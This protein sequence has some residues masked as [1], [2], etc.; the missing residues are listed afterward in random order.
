MIAADVGSLPSASYGG[1][2]RIGI[3]LRHFSGE[4]GVIDWA[5]ARATIPKTNPPAGGDFHLISIFLG[6]CPTW[7]LGAFDLGAC[8]DAELD[9]LRGSG[10][11]VS[12]T[13]E[14]S[15]R[16][17][18]VGASTLARLKISRHFSLPL[19]LGVLLPLEHP[20]FTLQGVA[21]DQGRVHKPAKLMGRATLGVDWVF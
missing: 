15:S 2:G 16:W 19:K 8:A 21:E 11:G 4:V 3:K 5:G 20:T 12:S 17:L 10:F 18:S 7:P 9:V 14:N 6:A 13:Y 1:G